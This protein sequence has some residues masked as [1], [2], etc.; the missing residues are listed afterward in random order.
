MSD[1]FQP[2]QPLLSLRDQFACAALTGVLA[3][4]DSISQSF[5][6]FAKHAYQYADAMMTQ[7]EAQP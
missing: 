2:I 4:P 3:H 1:I 6:L 5:D 7:R